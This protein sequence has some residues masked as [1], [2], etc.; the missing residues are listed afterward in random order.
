M[1]YV[2]NEVSNE[3][4]NNLN[5]FKLYTYYYDIIYTYYEYI[6]IVYTNL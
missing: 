3:K 2:G 5:F 6:Y 1:S 4:I